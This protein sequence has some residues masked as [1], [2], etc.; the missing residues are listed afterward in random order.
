VDFGSADVGSNGHDN[1]GGNLGHDP[2][3]PALE[4]EEPSTSGDE[5]SRDAQPEML[6]KSGVLTAIK[7]G[8]Q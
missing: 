8:F 6:V 3:A 2:D 5:G 4:D 1:H 7:A